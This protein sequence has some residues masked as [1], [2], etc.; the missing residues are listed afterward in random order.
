MCTS[1]RLTVVRRHEYSSERG[2]SSVLND[3]ELV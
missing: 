3:M 1:S 2:G